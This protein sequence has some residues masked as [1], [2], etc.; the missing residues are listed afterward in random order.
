[1]TPYEG[2]ATFLDRAYAALVTGD[3]PPVGYEDM[4]GPAALI[5]ALVR[6]R[7]EAPRTAGGSA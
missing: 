4:R 3:E 7:G 2:L 1:M 5:D 6:A